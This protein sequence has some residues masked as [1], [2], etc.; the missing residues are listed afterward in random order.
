MTLRKAADWFV[1][2]LIVVFSVKKSSREVKFTVYPEPRNQTDIVA[3]AAV[4]E[5]ET[6]PL[7]R[8]MIRAMAWTGAGRWT[9]QLL[10]WASTIVVAR[11]LAPSDYGLFGMAT[12]YLGMVALISEFGLGQAVITLREM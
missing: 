10:T 9:T 8:A 12:L 5:P 1:L 4:P 2:W 7:D 6:K 3:E 11:I